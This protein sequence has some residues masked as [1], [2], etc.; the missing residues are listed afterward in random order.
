MTFRPYVRDCERKVT[1][2]IIP[3]RWAYIHLPP[4]MLPGSLPSLEDLFA[5]EKTRAAHLRRGER[6]RE[7]GRFGGFV[8]IALDREFTAAKRSLLT[9][10]ARANPARCCA[11]FRQNLHSAIQRNLSKFTVYFTE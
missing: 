1:D 5:C 9:A 4:A 8:I 7:K 6:A 2:S 11:R 10:V 3:G